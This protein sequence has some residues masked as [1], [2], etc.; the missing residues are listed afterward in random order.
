MTVVKENEL[1]EWGTRIGKLIEP[2]M[3]LLLSGPLGSGKSVLARSIAEGM[4]VKT[5]V[6][7]PTFNLLITYPSPRGYQIAHLDLYRLSDPRDLWELGWEDLGVKDQIVIVEWPERA[8]T[9][10]PEDS[11]EIQLSF[12]EG[13]ESVRNLVIE[14]HGNPGFL[15]S[16]LISASP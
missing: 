13:E 3:F 8:D 16:L 2:P 4:G 12:V 1:V 10:L 5:P 6:I 9:F 15:P 7:S 11:W 14:K